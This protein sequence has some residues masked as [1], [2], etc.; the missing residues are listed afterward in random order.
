[1]KHKEIK[2]DIEKALPNTKE[3]VNKQGSILIEG[4]RKL[5]E[6]DEEF[7]SCCFECDKE[8]VL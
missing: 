2:I 5:Y 6:P 7:K 4:K 1:M 8:L 3:F